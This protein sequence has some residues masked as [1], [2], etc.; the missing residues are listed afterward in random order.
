VP[1]PLASRY[2]ALVV[3]GPTAVGKSE[4]AVREALRIG[5]EIVGADAFQIYQGLEILTAQ[6]SAE[7]RRRVPH[8]LFGEIPLATPFDVAQYLARAE[9][10]LAAIRA[11]GNVPVIAGGTGLYI[12]ALLRGLADLPAS[13]PALRAELSAQPLS[14]LQQRLAQLD[15]EGAAAIDLQNPRRVI[16]ALEICLQTGRPFSS[17]REEWNHPPETECGI[18]LQRKRE[19][20]YA[21]IDRRVE[22][23]LSEGAIEEVQRIGEAIGATA[24]QTLGWTEIRRMLSGELSREACRTA[25]QQATRRYAKR[26]LTWFQRERGLRPVDLSGLA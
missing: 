15:P 7:L 14:A 18:L 20:L 8:H 21:R 10:V 23:M 2:Q 1:P 3:A 25:I 24:R 5:G 6:P 19:E 16:R 13:D 9:P 17:F 22:A 12:R 26:Q 11:R 4:F